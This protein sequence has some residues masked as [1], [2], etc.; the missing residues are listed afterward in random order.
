MEQL[1]Q[2]R[3]IFSKTISDDCTRIEDAR[4]VE[5]RHPSPLV[6]EQKRV[7][8]VT[9]YTPNGTAVKRFQPACS[10]FSESHE[11]C[12]LSIAC[13]N[14]GTIK[15]SFGQHIFRHDVTF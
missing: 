13:L 3:V 2:P 12:D 9:M 6:N 15:L 10:Q 4:V 1:P 8:E 14:G 5:M 7:L 11:G